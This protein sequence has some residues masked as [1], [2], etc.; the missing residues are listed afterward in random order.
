VKVK[1]FGSWGIET[2]SLRNREGIGKESKDRG[3][4]GRKKG[5]ENER[6]EASLANWPPPK[7]LDPPLSTNIHL[8]VDQVK[9]RCRYFQTSKTTSRMPYPTST[10]PTAQYFSIC[11]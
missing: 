1:G 10:S 7:I 6:K 9:S 8:S 4:K 5:K 3:V 2:D 11:K